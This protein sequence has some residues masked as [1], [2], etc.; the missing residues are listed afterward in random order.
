MCVCVYV[1]V[2]MCVFVGV[3]YVCVYMHMCALCAYKTVC[4]SA[5]AYLNTPHQCHR[6]VLGHFLIL[7]LKGLSL[8]FTVFFWVD[9]QYSSLILLLLFLI[10]DIIGPGATTSSVLCRCVGLNSGHPGCLAHAQPLCHLSKLPLKVF[11]N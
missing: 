11:L 9:N 6:K 3:A 10:T 4:L 5:P 2:Q 1:C 8:K 7:F